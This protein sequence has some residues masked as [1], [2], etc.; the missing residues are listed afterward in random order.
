[1]EVADREGFNW[2]RTPEDVIEWIEDII[3]VIIFMQLYLYGTSFPIFS[4]Q[5][6]IYNRF[7]GISPSIGTIPFYFLLI[8]HKVHS[9]Y[10]PDPEV[11]KKIEARFKLKN[12]EMADTTA[13]MLMK[14]ALKKQKI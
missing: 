8:T 9:S 11:K 1:M 7:S 4:K 14:N 12:I 10:L 2:S 13:F 5:S 6:K 3:R